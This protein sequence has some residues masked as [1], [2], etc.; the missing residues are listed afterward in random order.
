MVR[1]KVKY[2]R[3]AGE[4]TFCTC[5]QMSGPSVSSNSFET[6][7]G[8]L[9]TSGVFCLSETARHELEACRPPYIWDDPTWRF[10]ASRLQLD[11]LMLVVGAV[12]V[13]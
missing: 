1:R 10:L 8:D 13:K 11:N 2:T 7:L 12:G 4:A 3:R 9:A 5:I 6:F